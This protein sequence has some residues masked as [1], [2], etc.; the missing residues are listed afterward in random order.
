M[1]Q[2]TQIDFVG[3][4][5]IC[6]SVVLTRVLV[7]IYQ[8]AHAF[9]KRELHE[10]LEKPI[11]KVSKPAHIGCLPWLCFFL[12]APWNSRRKTTTEL[13][14]HHCTKPS[15]SSCHDRSM[16][17]FFWPSTPLK[18]IGRPA[19]YVAMRIGFLNMCIYI[20]PTLL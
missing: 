19:S 7:K 9:P 14:G 2:S 20:Y 1:R 4:L 16:L 15:R 10:N 6:G 13:N 17:L 8:K 5:L 3:S 11:R 18:Y 12:C